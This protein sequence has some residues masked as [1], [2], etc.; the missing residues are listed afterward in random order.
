[1]DSAR[2]SMHSSNLQCYYP[3]KVDNLSSYYDHVRTLNTGIMVQDDATLPL[4]QVRIKFRQDMEKQLRFHFKCTS[5]VVSK[6]RTSPCIPFGMTVHLI[7]PRYATHLCTRVCNSLRLSMGIS[8]TIDIVKRSE[9]MSN[10]RRVTW[11][12]RVISKR[13][14]HYTYRIKISL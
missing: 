13:M 5:T 2:N 10:H 11:L 4:R 14:H 9:R 7:T 3:E 8:C 12:T 6:Y 1:M